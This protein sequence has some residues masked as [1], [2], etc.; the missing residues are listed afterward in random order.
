M[1]NIQKIRIETKSEPVTVLADAD[2]GTVLINQAS[3][4]I[5][6]SVDDLDL[7]CRFVRAIHNEVVA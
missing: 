6:M 3:K 5:V 7:V 4:T 1:P 2:Q